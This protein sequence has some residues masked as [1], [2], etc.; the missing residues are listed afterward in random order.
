MFPTLATLCGAVLA[1]AAAYA[2]L[3][4]E[5]KV[6][7]PNEGWTLLQW[8]ANAQRWGRGWGRRRR[9]HAPGYHH[10]RHYHRHYRHHHRGAQA[11]ARG[12]VVGT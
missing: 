3:A 2:E 10:H 9:H 1:G 4:R 7:P 11:A 5:N 12:R 8:L 6:K